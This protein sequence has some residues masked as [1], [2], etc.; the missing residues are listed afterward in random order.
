MIFS[1]H[2]NQKSLKI[3]PYNIKD[4][5]GRIILDGSSVY[6]P[7]PLLSQGRITLEDGSSNTR[8]SSNQYMQTYVSGGTAKFVFHPNCSHNIVRQP[9]SLPFRA[10]SNSQSNPVNDIGRVDIRWDGGC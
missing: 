5:G 10:T 4:Y 1:K 7:H 3:V 9:I 2:S 6:I 8:G